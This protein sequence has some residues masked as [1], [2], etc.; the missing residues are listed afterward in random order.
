VKKTRALLRGKAWGLAVSF[1]A[2]FF[3]ISPA[4]QAQGGVT[5]VAVIDVRRLVTDSVAGKEAIA[6]LRQLQD[7]R[8]SEG[9][10]KQEEIEQLRKR[11]NDGRMSLAEDRLAQLERELEE[12]MTALRR[13]QEDAERELNKSREAAFGEIER[14]VGPI[15]EQVGTEGGYTLIFNKFESGLVF[16][17]DSADITDEIIRRFDAQVAKEKQ[18]GS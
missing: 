6:K 1:F 14:R 15:I 7:Q 11:I 13:F 5:R 17:A 3:G 4:M 16:A 12:K 10:S 8:I 9:R 2:L 18:K